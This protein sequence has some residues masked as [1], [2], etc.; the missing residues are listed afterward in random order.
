M[1]VHDLWEAA[2]SFQSAVLLYPEHHQRFSF[3]KYSKKSCLAVFLSLSISWMQTCRGLAEMLQD[4]IKC[5]VWK[6]S[7]IWCFGFPQQGHPFVCIWL[8]VWGF[9][10]ISTWCFT[11]KMVHYCLTGKEKSVVSPSPAF[12]KQHLKFEGTWGGRTDCRESNWRLRLRFDTEF[13][14]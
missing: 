2:V 12:V 14:I 11:T 7:F 4:Q 6:L 10:S 13:G 3:K 9:L 1:Y 5:S 8:T